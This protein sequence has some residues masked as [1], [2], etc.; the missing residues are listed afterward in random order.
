MAYKTEYIAVCSPKEQTKKTCWWT[1]NGGWSNSP[2]GARM[3]AN[4]HVG[5]KDLGGKIER[6]DERKVWE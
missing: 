4:N 5:I 3:I 1:C 2:E 6:I